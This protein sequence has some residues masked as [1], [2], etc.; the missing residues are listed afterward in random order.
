M[1]YEPARASPSVEKQTSDSLQFDI[2]RRTTQVMERVHDR[3]VGT[4][5]KIYKN[6]KEKRIYAGKN[7]SSLFGN[8]NV[9]LCFL[10]S[11]LFII[12]NEIYEKNILVKLPRHYSGILMLDSV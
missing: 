10:N 11:V 1:R 9:G 8:S 4:G 12:P 2:R 6:E 7:A 3:G 5:K